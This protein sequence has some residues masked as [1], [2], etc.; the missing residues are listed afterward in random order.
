MKKIIG[1]LKEY[2]PE[3]FIEHLTNK[4]VAQSEKDV[5]KSF[6]NFELTN[7]VINALL[8]YMFFMDHQATW[9]KLSKT[10]QFFHENH[11]HTAEEAIDTMKKLQQYES[12]LD[13]Q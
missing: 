10:A 6:R 5:I 8:Y 1:I 12:Q 13:R 2:S 9:D 7:P 11:I 3:Q 4:P